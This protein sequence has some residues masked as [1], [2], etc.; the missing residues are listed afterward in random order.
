MVRLAPFAALA[1]LAGCSTDT[2]VPPPTAAT[3]QASGAKHLTPP[4]SDAAACTRFMAGIAVIPGLTSVQLK[5]LPQGVLSAIVTRA[6]TSS[7]PNDYGL[8]VSDRAM[9]A[10]DLDRLAGNVVADLVPSAAKHP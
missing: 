5:I 2:A 10:D 8:A 4:L 3:C 6:G 7:A 1:I 9:T